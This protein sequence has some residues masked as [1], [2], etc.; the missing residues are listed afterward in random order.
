MHQLYAPRMPAIRQH[1]SILKFQVSRQRDYPRLGWLFELQ[2]GARAL[3][4]ENV[5][6]FEDGLVEG[7]WGGPFDRFG[8]QGLT[9]LFGSG[10]VARDG[11]WWFCAP[12][13]TLDALYAL[14]HRGQIFV[15]NSLAILFG[16]VG[17]SPDPAVNYT[18]RLGTVVSGLDA[19]DTVIWRDDETILYRIIGDEF[20]FVDGC[21]ERRRRLEPAH[22]KNFASYR[23][24]LVQTLA[25]CQ[26][27]ARDP[28]RRQRYRFVSTCS[29]GYDSN[30]AA[31]LAA[32]LGGDQAITLRSARRGVPDSGI[33]VAGALGLACVEHDRPAA[34]EQG[35]EVEFLTTGTGGGDYPL[36]SFRRELDGAVL[37]T[38]YHGDKVWE[39]TV[40]PQRGAETWRQFGLQPGRFPPAHR[41]LPHTGTVHRCSTASGD[42][43]HQQLGGVATL[44]HRRQL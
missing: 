13:H 30:T 17:I 41:L 3:C 4:G 14:Q 29:G 42:P 11:S 37:L 2:R 6:V 34:G 31:A 18:A 9:T 39:R 36:G 20:R 1:Q 26:E 28:A 10:V 8:F 21:L 12:S 35:R 22:F 15:A 19:A 23:R 40:A 38:G 33:Q 27:N 44:L 32:A 7:C 25:A 5:E 43:R 16:H 24:H